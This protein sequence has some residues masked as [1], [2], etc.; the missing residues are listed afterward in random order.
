MA[1]K[2][3]NGLNSLGELLRSTY[4]NG[5]ALGLLVDGADCNLR[6][7]KVQKSSMPILHPYKG[8]QSC[9]NGFKVSFIAELVW[10]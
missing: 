9:R 8:V 7:N 4:L 3:P 6:F 1:D 2:S 5:Y 10:H